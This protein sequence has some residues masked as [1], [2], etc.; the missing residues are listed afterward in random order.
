MDEQYVTRVVLRPQRSSLYSE[1]ETMAASHL[2]IVTLRRLRT[3][4]LIEGKEHDGKLL[5]SE[6]EIIQLRRIRRLQQELG[7]NLAGIEVILH[8]LRQIETIHQELEQEKKQ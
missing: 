5:Y 4:G 1:R 2:N 8:L 6:E 7:V 3:L